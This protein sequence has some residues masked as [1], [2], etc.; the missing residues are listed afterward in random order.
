MFWI[1]MSKEL[2]NKVREV[3]ITIQ[4]VMDGHSHMAKNRIVNVAVRRIMDIIQE[5]L[6][7]KNDGKLYVT[8]DE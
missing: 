6:E 7:R 4:D 3:V 8:S 2:E 5:E 1:G